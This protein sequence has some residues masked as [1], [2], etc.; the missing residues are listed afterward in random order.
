M[1]AATRRPASTAPKPPTSISASCI[2]AE[3]ATLMGTYLITVAT[4]AVIQPRA[5]LDSTYGPVTIGDGCIVWER[6]SIGLLSE[7]EDEE[8]IISEGVELGKNV[9][10]EAGAIV[11]AQSI[12]EGTVIEVGARIGKGSVLGKVF[13][14]PHSSALLDGTDTDDRIQHC[15][16]TPLSTIAPGEILSDHIVV[17]GQN[18]RRVGKPGLEDPRESTHM[19]QLEVMRTLI[20]NNRAK[21]Q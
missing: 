12:G 10:V 9:T 4:N 1:S 16:I 14:F 8:G 21:W 5:K 2:I 15:K 20:P 6:A 17:Y 18:V 11:E 19:K 3:T 13:D 7:V